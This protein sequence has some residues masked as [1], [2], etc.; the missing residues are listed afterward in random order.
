MPTTPEAAYTTIVNR[1]IA[2]WATDAAGWDGGVA[3]APELRFHGVEKGP[4]PKDHFAR[5][6]MMNV[7]ERQ[8]TF[9]N[10]DPVDGNARYVTAGNIFIQ[11][12]APRSRETALQECRYLAT[13]ARNIFRG[14]SFDGCILFRNVRVVDL[15]D[16]KNFVRKNVVMEFEYDEIS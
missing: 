14:Q 12:F 2:E 15:D 3:A 9:R 1:F 8:R 7:L 11:V 6:A 13:A 4:I 5:F 10:G 16:E